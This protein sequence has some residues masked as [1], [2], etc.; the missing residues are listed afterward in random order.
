MKITTR[1]QRSQDAQVNWDDVFPP[2]NIHVTLDANSGD[3]VKL[4]IHELLHVV[5]YDMIVGRLD[6]TLEEVIIIAYEK[7]IYDYAQA[8]P[9]RLARWNRLVARRTDE[10]NPDLPYE[11]QVAR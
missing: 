5:L 3:P 8:S 2:T 9:K 1:A 6:A 10:S 7:Y 4:L 11:E